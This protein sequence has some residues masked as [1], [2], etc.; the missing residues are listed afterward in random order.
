[1]IVCCFLA[2]CVVGAA[3]APSG[4]ALLAG[5]AMCLALVGW[6]PPRTRRVTLGAA[7][8]VSGLGWA[9]LVAPWAVPYG[10]PEGLVDVAGTVHEVTC[11]PDDRCQARLLD[12]RLGEVVVSEPLTLTGYDDLGRQVSPG[13]RIAVWADVVGDR[14]DTNPGPAPPWAERRW[15]FFGRVAPGAAPRQS[16]DGPSWRA[17]AR[18]HLRDTLTLPG[19]EVTALFRALLLGE[20]RGLPPELQ[21]AF[22]DSGTAHLLAISGLHLAVVGFGLYRLLL[23]LLLRWRRLAQAGRPPALAAALA[24]GLTFVYVAAIAPSQATL[25]ATIALGVVFAGAVLARRARP[26]PTLAVAAA[27]LIM[28]D[29]RAPRGASFQLSF[30]AATALVLL[31]AHLRPLLARLDEPG[32]LPDPRWRGP[33]RALLALVAVSLVSTAVTTPLALAWFGQ[34]SLAAPLCNLVAVPLMSL[35]VVPLGFAWLILALVAPGLAALLAPLPTIPAG[36]LLDLVEGWAEFV[37][38]STQPAWPHLAGLAAALALI[39]LLAGRR[40]RVAA[41]GA[42]LATIALLALA[43]PPAGELRLTAI[44]VGH[45]DA[46]VVELPSGQ[47]VM[48]DTGGHHR[49][50][51]DS[52]L[53]TGRLVPALTR[54]GIARLD[55]LIITHA[56][57]DHVG[58]AAALAERVPIDELW[59]P[60]CDA[61]SPAVMAVA[62][63]VAAQGGRVRQVHQAPP[64]EFGGASLE[65]LWPPPEL[66]GPDG[67]CEISKNDAA[68]VLSLRYAGRHLLLTADIEKDTEAALLAASGARLRADILK[69]GH[70]GSRSSSSDA[71]LDAVRPR[72]AVASGRRTRSTMPPHLDILERYSQRQIPL[73]LTGRDGAV[74]VAIEA[75]GAIRVASQLGRSYALSAEVTAVLHPRLG[76]PRETLAASPERALRPP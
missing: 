60:A 52:R 68:L 8:L 67:R 12:V 33:A 43:P 2:G 40:Y 15:R 72:I 58:A 62:R 64:T 21:R 32:A 20:R 17:T 41:A 66:T 34:A 49:A 51:A 24:G 59:L 25:R 57:H 63:R 9:G 5:L 70:H 69:V 46:L 50:G 31:A 61:E 47:T 35:L 11:E 7:A 76:H 36:W 18:A 4:F 10:S 29:P 74:R 45:G 42:A 65:I 38:P 28:A 13:E 71:F 14:A 27:V 55:L 37:G 73:W 48:V 22:V 75:T 16:P 1:M 19:A 39:F 3:L 56:D 23:A 26:L 44:D 30:A 53:A 54:L 6:G